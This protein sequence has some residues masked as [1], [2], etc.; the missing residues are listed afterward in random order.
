MGRS[1]GGIQ[2]I[3]S[4]S[5]INLIPT[6]PIFLRINHRSLLQVTT[7]SLYL[8]NVIISS[9]VYQILQISSTAISLKAWRSY[10]FK[11]EVKQYDYLIYNYLVTFKKICSLFNQ[12]AEQSFSS[13][14][15]SQEKCVLHEVWSEFGQ[16][17]DSVIEN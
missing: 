5:L 3:T 15:R 11:K 6:M 4:N 14:N 17:T 16:N 7:P 2:E 13:P 1:Y 8:L 9:I 12:K 10:A